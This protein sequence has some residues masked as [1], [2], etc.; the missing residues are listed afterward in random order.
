MG[1]EKNTKTKEELEREIHKKITILI[2]LTKEI[3][4]E[5]REKN[6]KIINDM[7]EDYHALFGKYYIYRQT[8]KKGNYGKG[9]YGDW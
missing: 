1:I 9:E 3:P 7:A 8:P 5:G 2:D 4:I 6:I